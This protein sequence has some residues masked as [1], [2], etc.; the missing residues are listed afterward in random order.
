[1]YSDDWRGTSLFSALVIAGSYLLNL[2]EIVVV[3]LIAVWSDGN[4]AEK[5]K[6]SDLYNPAV[7]PNHYKN[8]SS[9]FFYV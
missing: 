4:Q 5:T 1:M 2:V 8:I 3:I 6:I 7:W 9:W